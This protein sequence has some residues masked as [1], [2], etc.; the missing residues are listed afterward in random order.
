[1]NTAYRL[2]PTQ[3]LAP[4]LRQ[5]I[6]AQPLRPE[7]SGEVRDRPDYP[8]VYELRQVSETEPCG[9]ELRFQSLLVVVSFWLTGV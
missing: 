4:Y 6:T 8:F 3:Q 2:Q 5:Y 1:M 9:P 7:G